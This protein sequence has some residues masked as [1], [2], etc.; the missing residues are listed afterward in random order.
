M[1]MLFYQLPMRMIIIMI[2]ANETFPMLCF[3]GI[4]IESPDFSELFSSLQ[5]ERKHPIKYT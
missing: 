1:V 2:G 5:A 3:K 4:L